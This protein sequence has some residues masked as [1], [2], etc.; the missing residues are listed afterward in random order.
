MIFLDTSENMS[1]WDKFPPKI[2]EEC[3]IH[4]DAIKIYLQ[5]AEVIGTII[6]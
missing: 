5:G 6:Q 4:G 3:F 1:L 2:W